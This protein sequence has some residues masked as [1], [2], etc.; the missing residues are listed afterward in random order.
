[1]EPLSRTG[2]MV[3]DMFTR[4][5]HMK[6]YLKEAKEII[7]FLDWCMKLTKK[8]DDSTI[9]W[10]MWERCNRLESISLRKEQYVI[11]YLASKV[12][13]LLSQMVKA[14]PD[15]RKQHLVFLNDFFDS[16]KRAF[17]HASREKKYYI[18]TESFEKYDK[19]IR[20]RYVA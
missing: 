18:K 9:I 17:N 11:A 20:E 13:S 16:L 14:T 5:K 6:M 15:E 8:T 12:S 10:V 7:E 3:A 4:A 19:L 2:T 1:M